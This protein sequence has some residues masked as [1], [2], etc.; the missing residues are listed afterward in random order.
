MYVACVSV[1]VKWQE[2]F[3]IYIYTCCD[4]CAEWRQVLSE[5][6]LVLLL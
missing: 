3:S 4:H 2:E 1:C 6:S 5:S